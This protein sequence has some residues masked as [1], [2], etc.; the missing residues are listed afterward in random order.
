MQ[1]L[2]RRT[3]VECV[4]EVIA[5]IALYRPGPMQFIDDFLDRKFGRVTVEYD[6]PVMEEILQETY[7]IMVYQEQVMQVVQK[8][9]GFSLG[10]ADILRR[11]MG[12]KK[13]DVMAAQLEK[14][15]DGC[16]A[17]SGLDKAKAKAIWDKIETFAGYGFN[18]SHSAAY[19]MLSMRTAYLRANYPVEFMCANL[20]AEVG[21]SERISELTAECN[22]MGIQ[23]L[24]P[25]VNS[26]RE[27]FTVDGDT[28]RF[29]LAAIKGS[30]EIAA[31]AIIESREKEGPFSSLDEFCERI[32]S[33]I[34]KRLLESLTMTGAFDSFGLK[35][36]Q[37]YAML[38]DV[39]KR[40]QDTIR[41][42]ES[43]QAN[44]FDLMA[45][46]EEDTGG[47]G[48]TVAV[49]DIDEWSKQELLEKEKELLGFYVTGHPLDDYAEVLETFRVHDVNT[50]SALPNNRGTRVGGMITLVMNKISKRDGRPWAIITIEDLG[51]S[52]ECLCFADAYAECMD[53]I[54]SGAKVFIEGHISLREGD[55][56]STIMAK[57][58]I[59]MEDA[60]SLYAREV[61]L[62]VAEN[63]LEPQQLER[64][65]DML[66]QHPGN[67]PVVL[68]LKLNAGGFAFVEAGYEYRIKLTAE[69]ERELKRL[70]YEGHLKIKAHKKVEDRQERRWEGRA[71]S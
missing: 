59:P 7:G 57:K 22:K 12:K 25:D 33:A 70:C 39:I 48:L 40:A 45:G 8:V 62:G 19:A 16:L 28:I 52:M 21:N 69:V 58:I 51:G 43:G 9:A 50:A 68:A 35:R 15:I 60:G 2:C 36:S 5:L 30:G 32:G 4:E 63:A 46:G 23:V 20:C 37:M 44:F 56:K 64:I 42:R 41:D 49:P 13:A 27:S 24:P 66:K 47:S 10:G 26:S 55:E 53:H 65:K 38:D 11:A 67:V 54:H 71:A 6:V 31:K 29:G 14:F 61:H 3:K 1:N 17:H 34:N 18:K